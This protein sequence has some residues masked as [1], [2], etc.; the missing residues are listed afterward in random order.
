M[1]GA[2]GFRHQRRSRRPFASHAQPE[3]KTECGKLRDAAR[4]PAGRREHRIDRNAQHQSGAASGAVG[5]ESEE[6]AACGRGDQSDRRQRSRLRGREMEFAEK[7][8]NDHRVKGHVHAVEHPAERAG[9]KRAALPG[10]RCLEKTEGVCEPASH[11][12]QYS[13]RSRGRGVPQK[14]VS[15]KPSVDKLSP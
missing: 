4:E 11:A 9:Q 13:L 5:E 14:R 15:A 6:D 3:Q 7:R 2:P 10:R 1:L 8:G 12:G